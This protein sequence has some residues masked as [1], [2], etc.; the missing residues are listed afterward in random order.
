M[1]RDLTRGHIIDFNPFSPRTDPLLFTY[2]E[3]HHLFTN[4]TA[5]NAATLPKLVVIASRAHPA[6]NRQAPQ[7]QHNMMPFDALQLSSGRDITEFAEVWREEVE[8]A[9]MD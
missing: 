1:T 9:A 8:G 3:L 4:S 6:A 5:N 2:E 7:N